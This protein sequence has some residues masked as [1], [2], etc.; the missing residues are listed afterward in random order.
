MLQKNSAIDYT[1]H[2]GIQ[3][4]D[5]SAINYIVTSHLFVIDMLQALKKLKDNAF[6]STLLSVWN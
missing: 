2:G 5:S 3:P 6:V 1:M 4:A